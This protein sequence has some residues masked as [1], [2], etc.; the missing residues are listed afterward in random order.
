MVVSQSVIPFSENKKWGYKKDHKIII[1]P[2]YDTAFIFDKTNQI[3]LVANKSEFNKVVNPLS[4]EEEYAFD[5]FY[6]DC[7]NTKI[8]LL[9]EH[10]PDSIST[11]TNQQELQYNYR[12]SS[13]YFKIIFENK[14]YLFSKKG[15]QLSIG[16]DNI[17]ETKAKGYFET[18]NY[19]EFGKKMVRTKGLID[20]TG[21]VVVKCKYHKVLINKEDSSIYCCSVVYN[22][23]LNDD[24]YNYKGKLIYTNQKHIEFSS[25]TIHVMK[26]YEPREAFIIE[27]SET[28]DLLDFEGN[29]FYY[30]QKNKALFINK[31]NWFVIDLKS[32][33]KQKVDKEVYF[34][35]LFILS[36]N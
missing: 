1:T 8:K 6:I 28:N 22:N 5:Y 3:A 36:E 31:D 30:L 25:K 27:N 17:T 32:K 21:L 34:Q 11:F 33:K 35:N 2:Q 18:E 26:S 4:G 7:H 15:K 10:F 12:D 9:A 29:D 16:Y 19:S 24:V 23:K 14:I 13:D 20:S